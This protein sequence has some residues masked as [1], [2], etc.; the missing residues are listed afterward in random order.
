L[1]P[2]TAR[3]RITDKGDEG[4]I[5]MPDLNIAKF[6]IPVKIKRAFD[7]GKIADS[8]KQMYLV[9]D[10]LA[11]V[12]ATRRQ[13]QKAA[14]Y[15]VNIGNEEGEDQQSI[16]KTTSKVLDYKNDRIDYHMKNMIHLLEL[17]VTSRHGE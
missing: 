16:I 15:I 5:N 11:S 4:S 3:D 1:T 8:Y 17:Y 6:N 2:T 9:A 7:N 14:E 13:V 10:K 12:E